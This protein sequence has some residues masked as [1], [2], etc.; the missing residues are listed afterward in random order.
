MASSAEYLL[1]LVSVPGVNTDEDFKELAEWISDI[2]PRVEVR[3]CRDNAQDFALIRQCNRPSLIFSPGPLR[4]LLPSQARVL[5]GSWLPKSVE[6][7]RLEAL[8][9]PIP[10]WARLT[11]T[12]SPSVQDFGPYVVVKPDLGARGAD[13]RIARSKGLHWRPPTTRCARFLGGPL[14]PFVVQKFVY[15]GP[16]ACSY[17]VSTLCGEVLWS[18]SIEASHDHRPLLGASGFASAE[19][20]A[21]AP[22]VS[23]G[24]GC[25]ISLSNLP[26]VLALARRA[27]GAFPDMALLGFDLLRDHST[28]ELCIV[29]ANSAGLCW[30]FSSDS[31]NRLQDEFG[32]RLESQ[33]NGRR[34]AA[35]ILADRTVQLAR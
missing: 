34:R 10:R 5:Q 8:D 3:I 21:G 35:R 16:W 29:E 7:R 24:K 15:T 22:I 12:N 33:F 20:G 31:G 27:H 1:V 11:P 19:Q 9:L 32:F 18:T 28:G 25:K 6:Y 4:Q 23:S 2:E 17:R 13:V 26:D 30:H 14:A